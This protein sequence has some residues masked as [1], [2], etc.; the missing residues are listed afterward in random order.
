MNKDLIPI[1]ELPPT[2]R[3]TVRIDKKRIVFNLSAVELM[4]VKN[5][6]F[7]EF[8]QDKSDSRDIYLMPNEEGRGVKLVGRHKAL[9]CSCTKISRSILKTFDKEKLLFEISNEDFNGRKRVFPVF[10]R[11]NLT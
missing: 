7:I 11:K 3:P 1:E 2:Y 10:T 8:L 9:Q 6:E 4:G 5:G